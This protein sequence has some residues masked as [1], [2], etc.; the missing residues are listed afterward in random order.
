MWEVRYVLL[1]WL[2]MLVRI[3]FDLKTADSRVSVSSER[4][5]ITDIIEICK[6][7]LGKN[8]PEREAAAICIAR[9]FSRFVQKWI[10]FESK[11]KINK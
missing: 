6:S 1:L 11:N 8:G 3:P 4:N 5:I 7:Y 9:L 2:S 10:M